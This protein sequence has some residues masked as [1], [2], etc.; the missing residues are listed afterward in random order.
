MIVLKPNIDILVGSYW[1]KFPSDAL[2]YYDVVRDDDDT[3]FIYFD[4]DAT[5][6]LDIVL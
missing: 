3:S 5:S 1:H 6:D 2:N 4:I